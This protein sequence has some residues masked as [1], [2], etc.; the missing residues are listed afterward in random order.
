MDEWEVENTERGSGG[1]FVLQSTENGKHLEPGQKYRPKE[2][3]S[4]CDM[5]ELKIQHFL[6][7]TLVKM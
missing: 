2:R 5:Y 4:W 7:A 6:L 3:Q 1:A